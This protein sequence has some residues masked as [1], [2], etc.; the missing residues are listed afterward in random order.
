MKSKAIVKAMV[1][2]AIACSISATGI[3]AD[4]NT[5]RAQDITN[6]QQNIQGTEKHDAV[7]SNWMDRT[8]I[9][10]GTQSKVGTQ[11]SIETLQPLTHYD[12]NS[13]SVLFV[14]GGIGKGGQERKVSYFSGVNGGAWYPLDPTTGKGKMRKD[15]LMT[16]ETH[17]IGTVANVG[18]GYRHLSKNEHAYVG[19]NAFVDRAFSENANRLSGGVEYVSGLN[20]VRVNVYRGLG[21]A[22]IKHRKI[23][24]HDNYFDFP[25][26]SLTVDDGVGSAGVDYYD[27]YKVLSGYDISYARTFKNARWARVQLGL[28][29]W[30]GHDVPTHGEYTKEPLHLGKSHGWQVGT[31]LQITPHISLDLGYTS[32]S[33]YDSGA[34]GFIKYTLGTSK[35]AW[36]GGKHSDDTITNAR[37]RMLDKI[38]RSPMMIGN[39]YEERWS[40]VPGDILP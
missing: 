3:A 7:Q 6:T 17:K 32:D 19:I 10:I 20:E 37:A 21:S 13:K 31:T 11:V 39:T 14:Q 4:I 35:F 23:Q 34:Y 33:K 30:N 38:E 12:E 26:N 28:Y 25:S 27:G 36:H 18:L 40:V 1:L 29:H 24:L 16:Y 15:Q 22:S 9:K 5:Q 8:D 2:G